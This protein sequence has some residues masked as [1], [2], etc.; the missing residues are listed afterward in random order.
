MYDVTN[1]SECIGCK[2]ASAL[3]GSGQNRH[4]VG[5]Y[6]SEINSSQS[7]QIP[8]HFYGLL[9]R[10]SHSKPYLLIARSHTEV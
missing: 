2:H 8:H 6:E 9:L 1:G 3:N 7:Q 5:G 4:I 10:S